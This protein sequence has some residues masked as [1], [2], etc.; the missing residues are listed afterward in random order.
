VSD[1]KSHKG[2]TLE[3]TAPISPLAAFSNKL[4]QL[5]QLLRQEEQGQTAHDLGDVDASPLEG[6]ANGRPAEAGTRAFSEFENGTTPSAADADYSDALG[7]GAAA[8]PTNRA[9]EVVTVL[10]E[11]RRSLDQVNFLYNTSRRLE[12]NLALREVLTLLVDILWQQ[13]HKFVAVLLGETE[14]GPYVYYEMRGVVDPLRFLGKPCPLP[15]WGEL[16]HALVRRLDPDEPDYLII[17]DIA[18][19]GRPKPQEFPWLERSGSLMIVPLRKDH[20]AMGALM[21]GRR[22]PHGFTDPDLCAELVEIAGMAAM[23]L[24]NAQVRHELQERADQLV[25]LQLFTRSLPISGSVNDLLRSTTVGIADLLGGVEVF[26]IIARRHLLGTPDCEHLPQFMGPQWRDLCV[27]G[28]RPQSGPDV[29]PN[30]LYRLVM[31]TIEAG[32]PLFFNPQQ[33]IG[34]PEDLYYNEAGRALLV[35]VSS[36]E[37][38][39]GAIFA[40]TRERP[41]HFDENDMVVARTMANI[42][43][44]VIKLNLALH[45]MPAAPAR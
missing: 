25:G 39:L 27:I 42:A 41:R 24:Y 11:L 40:I 4:H 2:T 8:L 1:I 29:L 37:D 31:W 16:A 20:V 43:A 32:Q 6:R 13:Q 18:P 17:D 22:E 14:L 36:S 33:E 3:P 34:A 5:E 28:S 38:S 19:S 30:S 45:Q 26:L 10:R 9:A 12:Q 15:L 21:L 44:A 23:A 35:P 7:N